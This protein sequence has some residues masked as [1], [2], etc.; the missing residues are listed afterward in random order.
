MKE[1]LTKGNGLQRVGILSH[2]AHNTVQN[3]PAFWS[4]LREKSG[5]RVFSES[6]NVDG[7]DV[8]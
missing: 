2:V 8:Q 3:S 4:L 1:K 6:K 7:S 5:L